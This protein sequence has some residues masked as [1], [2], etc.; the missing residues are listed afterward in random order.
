MENNDFSWMNNPALK[1]IDAA[2]LQMLMTMAAQGKGKSQNELLPFLMTAASKSKAG[3]T[4]FTR[5]ETDL[6]LN[7]LKQGKSP[8]EIAKMEQMVSLI[9][10]MKPRR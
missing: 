7:V 5:E 10:Q 8:E 9:R 6:I 4:S 1:N 3:G 2:K